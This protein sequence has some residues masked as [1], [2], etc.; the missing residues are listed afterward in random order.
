MS[1]KE[2]YPKASTS[3]P[4]I[5]FQGPVEPHAS[6]D[7]LF[8][9]SGHL[10]AILFRPMTK[11]HHSCVIIWD[12]TSGI[13]LSKVDT[14]GGY[15]ASF[16]LLSQ[17]VLVVS[18][19]SNFHEAR[20]HISDDTYGFLDM[21]PKHP[22]TFDALPQASSTIV[23]W[24]DWGGLAPVVSTAMTNTL[25]SGHRR[26]KPRN[27]F[28]VPAGGLVRSD[29]HE[30]VGK[31]AFC[32]GATGAC[33]K[34][35]EAILPLSEPVPLYNSV[36]VDDKHEVYNLYAS[37]SVR[38]HNYDSQLVNMP[39]SNR[40]FE[41]AFVSTKWYIGSVSETMKNFAGQYRVLLP[42]SYN[43][44]LEQAV[45]A[46]H[47][48]ESMMHYCLQEIEDLQPINQDPWWVHD[49]YK[50]ALQ[51]LLALCIADSENPNIY[52]ARFQSEM[53]EAIQALLAI[54][55]AN[56]WNKAI[57]YGTDGMAA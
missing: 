44:V 42:D 4:I 49:E 21:T 30:Q 54:E 45:I 50:A 25:Y 1:T 56:A 57:C 6:E 2:V 7:F 22:F 19:F 17:D 23:P 12:W 39:V 3:C 40:P 5:T 20:R 26:L 11:D 35:V 8:E 37:N 52:I 33:M 13:K 27:T 16:A 14:I 18:R 46:V 28:N 43:N 34:H 51:P 15:D 29:T 24:A 38:L 48:H 32:G 47:L 36:M 55:T 9:V 41:A 31:R 10:L 53:V